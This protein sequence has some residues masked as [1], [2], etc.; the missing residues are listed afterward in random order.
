MARLPTSVTALLAELVARPSTNAEGDSADSTATEV[1]TAK[2]V[3]TYLRQI[4]ADVEMHWLAPGRPNVVAVF[5]PIRRAAVTVAFVPHLDT[6]GVDGMTVPPFTLT[7]RGSRLCGRGTC[8]TKGPMAALFWALRRWTRSPACR[9][10][11]V[12]WVV[13]ATSGEEQGG[14]GAQALL[15][16]G[17]RVDFAIAL[18]PTGL[19]VIYAAKGVVRVWID[20]SGR[21]AHGATPALGVNAIYKAIPLLQALRDEVGPA[22][23]SHRHRV[24]G[25]ATL[26]LGTITGGSELNIV[27]S[28]CRLGLDIRI[29][30]TCPL[31]KILEIL[32]A[33]I[34]HHLPGARLSIHRV[35][36]PFVSDQANPWAKRLRQVGRGWAIAEW[37]CDANLFSEY[38]IPSVAFGPGNIRQAHTCDEFIDEAELAAG[39]RAFFNY[40]ANPATAAGDATAVPRRT[41]MSSSDWN[42]PGVRRRPEAAAIEHAGK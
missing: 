40:L 33:A 21:A 24:L 31:R 28:R 15:E 34:T 10:N 18:E 5:E 13:A 41:I 37:F 16:G 25:A 11:R 27:P 39:E 19:K 9:R 22:L 12:R 3:A 26:N 7:R 6:V 29:H 35:G 17:F 20:V 30:P 4:G 1:E 42:K 36:S 32:Q 14:L 23:T 8:D 38:D 2:W